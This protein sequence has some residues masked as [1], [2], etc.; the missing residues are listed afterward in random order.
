MTGLV[1]RLAGQAV[2][3]IALPSTQGGAVDLAALPAG[4]TVIYCYPRT[5]EPGKPPLAG[6]DV[7]TGAKG[8]TPQACT[9]RDHHDDLAAAGAVVYGLSTQTTA[10]QQEMAARLHLPFPILSDA[11]FELIDALSLPTFEAGGLRLVQ[12]L[13]LVIRRGVIEHVFHPVPHPEHSAEETLAWLRAHPIVD[14]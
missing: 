9:F 14:A 6:W 3:A 7:I 5:S 11:G 8:C 4:R 1:E 12:R 10:Y 13:T 2:P